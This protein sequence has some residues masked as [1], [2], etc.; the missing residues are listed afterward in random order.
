MYVIKKLLKIIIITPI[1]I[2]FSPFYF[3]VVFFGKESLNMLGRTI[4]K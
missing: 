1:I 2:T 4:H 3:H